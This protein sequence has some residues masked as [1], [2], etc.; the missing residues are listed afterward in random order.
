MPRL[1]TLEAWAEA[2]FGEAAPHVQTLRRWARESRIHPAPRRHGRAYFV[3][4]GAQYVDPLAPRVDN[5]STDGVRL[6]SVLAQRMFGAQT[7]S[8]V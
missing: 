6:S 8:R 4:P 3:E 7:Q 5:V 1:I 2:V